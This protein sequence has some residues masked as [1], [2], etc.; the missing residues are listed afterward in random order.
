MRPPE[1]QAFEAVDLDSLD[2][3]TKRRPGSCFI[4]IRRDELDSDEVE[5]IDPLCLDSS[6]VVW[7]DDDCQP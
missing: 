1:A 4:E 7:K 3:D 5:V 6:D 2:F